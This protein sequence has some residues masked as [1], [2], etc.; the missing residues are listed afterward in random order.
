MTKKSYFIIFC[1][2][3]AVAF[4]HLKLSNSIT[5]NWFIVLSPLFIPFILYGLFLICCAL[6][7]KIKSIINIY[8]YNKRET[9]RALERK[10]DWRTDTP[11][12]NI[13]LFFRSNGKWHHGSYEN[14]KFRI[15]GTKE[16]LDADTWFYQWRK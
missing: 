13:L 11:E 12:Q 1:E 14:G 5:W 15:L 9:K 7:G 8:Q 4:I 6:I 10:A 16:E 3:L 2:L